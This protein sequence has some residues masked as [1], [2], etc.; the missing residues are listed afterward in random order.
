VNQADKKRAVIQVDCCCPDA[1]IF[2]NK[3]LAVASILWP[4][5]WRKKGGAGRSL[6]Q[7]TVNIMPCRMAQKKAEP[8]DRLCK[9]KVNRTVAEL[10]WPCRKKLDRQPAAALAHRR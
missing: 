8:A 6:V 5:V 2:K 4:A 3:F 9:K 7:T 10:Q 1:D